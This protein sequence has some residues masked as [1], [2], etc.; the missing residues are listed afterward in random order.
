[1][2]KSHDIHEISV[3]NRLN[4]KQIDQNMR[5]LNESRTLFPHEIICHV[6]DGTEFKTNLSAIKSVLLDFALFNAHCAVAF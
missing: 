3:D 4:Y 2:S 1:M 5:H 6:I